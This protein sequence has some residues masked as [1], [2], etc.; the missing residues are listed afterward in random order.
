MQNDWFINKKQHAA[1]FIGKFIIYY[2][3]K[4]HDSSPLIATYNL[5]GDEYQ[6]L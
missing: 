2:K 5:W 3:F 4:A 1:Y 6:D